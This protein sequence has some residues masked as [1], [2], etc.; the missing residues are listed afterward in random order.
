[1]REMENC[2]ILNTFIHP[3]AFIVELNSFQEKLTNI[4]PQI[5]LRFNEPMSR[6][7]SFRIG[8]AAEA[9]AFPKSEAEL[10]QLL[11]VSGELDI[12]YAILGAGT[13]VLAPDEGVPGRRCLLPTMAFPVWNLPMAF[14]V[15]W[16]AAF[17]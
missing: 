5:E 10:S 7:T 12:S 1:M 9:M 6:H 11:K 4:L 2:G 16:A 14:P 13:N 8:G 3:E 15:R 17:I